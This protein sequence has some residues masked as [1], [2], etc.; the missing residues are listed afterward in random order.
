VFFDRQRS[1]AAWAGFG[2][3]LLN[4]WGRCESM[5][6]VSPFH[7]S[8]ILVIQFI[9]SEQNLGVAHIRWC[10]QRAACNHSAAISAMPLR[11]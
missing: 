9:S 5:S 10:P 7:Q 3:R 2:S 11:L 1:Y 6:E 8:T 4:R